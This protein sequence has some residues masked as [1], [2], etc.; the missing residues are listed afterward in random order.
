MQRQVYNL[1][2]L[3]GLR[4]ATY[5]V[6]SGHGTRKTSGKGDSHTPRAHLCPLQCRS[7]LVRPWTP[8]EC[9]TVGEWAEPKWLDLLGMGWVVQ[10]AHALQLVL[11]ASH[12]V[13][14]VCGTVVF[15]QGL[16]GR[17]GHEAVI[18]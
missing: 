7:G 15:P 16:S 4:G 3:Q 12:V 2:I 9:G 14:S 5:A 13:S 18:M 1:A 6:S 17:V 10:E 11:L 8:R